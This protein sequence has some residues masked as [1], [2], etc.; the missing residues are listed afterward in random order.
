MKL[1]RLI[2]LRSGVVR[3]EIAGAVAGIKNLNI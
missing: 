2:K 3:G 1:F